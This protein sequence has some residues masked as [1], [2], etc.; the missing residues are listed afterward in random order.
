ME[1]TAGWRGRWRN[2]HGSEL[3][4]EVEDGGRLRGW[5]KVDVGLASAAGKTVERRAFPLAGF[6]SGE[7]VSFSVG[8][9]RLHSI[10]AWAGHLVKTPDGPRIEASWQM[11]VGTPPDPHDI[12]SWRGTWTGFDVFRRG[13]A[14]VAAW[15]APSYPREAGPEP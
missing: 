5:L 6:V 2:Q 4:L 7:L 10:T 11:V 15:G 14:P 1:D 8:F 9:G 13:D 12:R 3:E